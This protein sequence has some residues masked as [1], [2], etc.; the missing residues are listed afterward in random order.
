MPR[1]LAQ[2]LRA[3]RKLRSGIKPADRIKIRA[4]KYSA[5]DFSEF[6]VHFAR[7][8]PMRG[9]S[10]SSRTW[11][12]MRWTGMRRRRPAPSPYGEV[13][14]SCRPDAGD[15]LATMLTHRADDGGKRAL[16]HRGERL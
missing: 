1:I 6:D 16:V 3:N 10:R 14:G 9:V 4:Q 8:A 11:R 13:A 7:S 2:P 12:G 5:F 15:K